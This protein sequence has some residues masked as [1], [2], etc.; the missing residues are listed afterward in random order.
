MLMDGVDWQPSSISSPIG[1]SLPKDAL[2]EAPVLNADSLM[3]GI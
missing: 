1:G 3:L 2:K